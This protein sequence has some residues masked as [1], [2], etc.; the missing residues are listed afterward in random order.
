[1]RKATRGVVITIEALAV[2]ALIAL[3]LTMAFF[4][5]SDYFSVKPKT[6][7]TWLEVKL[8]GSILTIKNVGVATAYIT[9]LYYE[10]NDVLYDITNSLP[11]TALAPGES[12]TV[13][14]NS[15][16]NEILLVGENFEQV[17]AQNECIQ[18]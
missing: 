18:P 15:A 2:S 6:S 8:C 7:Q 3:L 16:Y 11:Q 5:V 9:H 10:D 4:Y 12:I 17:V 13:T 1:M 14:L